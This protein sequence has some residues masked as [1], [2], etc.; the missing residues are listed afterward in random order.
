MLYFYF[1]Q[2]NPNKIID[3]ALKEEEQQEKHDDNNTNDENENTNDSDDIEDEAVN[4]KPENDDSEPEPID[5]IKDI[6]LETFV[7]TFD[8]FRN[9]DVNIVA[10]GDSLTQGIGDESEQGGYVGIIDRTINHNEEVVHFDNFGKNGNR[11]DQLLVRLED[12]DIV[13]RIEDAHIVLITIG[14]NDIMQVAKENF[15]NLTYD[16][17][18]AEQDHFEQR[19]NEIFE[20]IRDLNGNTQIYLLGIYNPF[21]KYFPEVEE[22]NQIVDDWNKISKRTTESYD[23]A[24]FI[25]VKDLFDDADVDLFSD[26]NFHPNIIGYE[27]MA[28]RVITY[29]RSEE[30]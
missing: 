22:L 8:F 19:L 10:I 1:K 15:T 30:R 2:P 5:Q 17:F 7:G 3:N 11:T 21:E 25:P 9:K 26:D 14:A 24:I 29:L 12:P 6:F 16:K 20:T 13:D 4:Q 23:D 28:K 27:R 18:A